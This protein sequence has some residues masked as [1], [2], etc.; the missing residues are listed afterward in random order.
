MTT[1][2][3]TKLIGDPGT[4]KLIFKVTCKEGKFMKSTRAMEVPGGCMVQTVTKDN[5]VDLGLGITSSLCFV[6]DVTVELNKLFPGSYKLV[7]IKI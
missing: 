3:D 1:N 2:N 5:D 6:P 4:W 7:P